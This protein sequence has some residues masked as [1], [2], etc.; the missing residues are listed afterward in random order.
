MKEK[1]IVHQTTVPYNPAQNGVSERISCT[2][3]ETAL[4]MMSQSKMPMEFWAEAVNIAVYLRNRS[5][6]TSLKGI[7]PIEALFD[8][9]PDVSHLKVFGCLAFAHIPKQQRKKFEEKSR[10]A[11]FVG[12]PDG[13]KG[14]KLYDVKSRRFIRSR[15]VIFAAKEFHD[16]D[17]GQ[18]LK[19][20]PIY[21]AP[22]VPD[23]IAEEDQ[24]AEEDKE[25]VDQAEP[26]IDEPA[27]PD[28]QPVGVTCEDNF[29]RKVKHLPPRGQRKP[30]VKFTE[31]GSYKVVYALS[32]VS[33]AARCNAH[34]V[35]LRYL[36]SK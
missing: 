17:N 35:A 27:V 5:P 2:I 25:N 1:R 26:E 7:T 6:S 8:R 22:N 33:Y 15:D 12:Y 28:N 34:C 24:I 20:D 23:V 13:T 19:L 21:D 3:I 30:P 36:P 32:A 11:V 18:S 9:K 16:F 4:S 31:E 14:Y 10:K 29:I